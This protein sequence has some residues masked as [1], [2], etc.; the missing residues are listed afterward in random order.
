MSILVGLKQK[1][2]HGAYHGSEGFEGFSMS[3]TEMTI[4]KE[5]SVSELTNFVKVG[6]D[7]SKKAKKELDQLET[8]SE[9]ME[10]SEQE[11]DKRYAKLAPLTRIDSYD[12]LIILEGIIL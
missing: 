6:R 1:E 8:E 4:L 10:M 7:V 11:F 2:A 5:G 12:K 9:R 3:G